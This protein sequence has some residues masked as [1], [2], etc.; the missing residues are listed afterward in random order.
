MDPELEALARTKRRRPRALSTLNRSVILPFNNQQFSLFKLTS[1]KTT[2]SEDRHKMEISLLRPLSKTG[3][4]KM[5]IRYKLQSQHSSAGK[6][7][8]MDEAFLRCGLVPVI[9]R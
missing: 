1:S 9:C 2:A 3:P 7:S 5:N 8:Q 6:V 4:S